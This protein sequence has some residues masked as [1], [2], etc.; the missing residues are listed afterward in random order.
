MSEKKLVLHIIDIIFYF[1]AGLL[2]LILP[3]PMMKWVG[4]IIGL[5]FICK[6][7]SRFIIGY[8][9]KEILWGYL[10]SGFYLIM[11]I[12]S[13]SLWSV[14]IT[15]LMTFV[16]LFIIFAGAIRLGGITF[17]RALMKPWIPTLIVGSIEILGGLTMI[18]TS[19]IDHNILAYFIGVIFLLLSLSTASDLVT[20]KFAKPKETFLSFDVEPQKEEKRK[21]VL[22]ADI[23]NETVHPHESNE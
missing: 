22:D 11:G 2:F 4:L 18:I 19:Y 20:E 6:A 8:V 21:D 1:V 5:Y 12:I 17:Q 9:K 3:E 14:V 23:V 10:V 7:I 15:L 13:I 16:G